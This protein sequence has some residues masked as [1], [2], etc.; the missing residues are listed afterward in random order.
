MT[1]KVKATLAKLYIEAMAQE[2]EA[3]EKEATEK[4]T[5]VSA[6]DMAEVV[7]ARLQGR[8]VFTNPRT[9]TRYVETKLG[10]KASLR[11]ARIA[12]FRFHDLRHTFATRAIRGGADVAKL[13][14]ILGH[15][16]VTTTMRYVHLATL[17]TTSVTGAIDLFE[18]QQKKLAEAQAAVAKAEQVVKAEQA[19]R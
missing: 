3:V 19:G 14:K 8:Y 15:K 2:K 17:D 5:H 13:Q 10:W 12:D 1:T 11:D 7:Q 18:E 9:G 4:V 16:D 6:K